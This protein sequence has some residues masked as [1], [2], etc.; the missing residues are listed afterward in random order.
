MINYI[1]FQGSGKT[2]AFAI[3]ILQYILKH[4]PPSDSVTRSSVKK[5]N[6]KK[7]KLSIPTISVLVSKN[8]NDLPKGLNSL[9]VIDLN[10]VSH[11]IVED[12]LDTGSETGNDP[13]IQE[14]DD[15]V[16]S[17]VESKSEEQLVFE[18]D[19]E[20]ENKSLTESEDQGHS[21]EVSDNTTHT[22]PSELG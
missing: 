9:K 10:E 6:K 18:I 12:Q 21:S 14:V 2:L 1:H 5:K 4:H 16:G 3:P 8:V 22:L 7:Q 11:S 19:S 15:D 17:D 13:A 20:T